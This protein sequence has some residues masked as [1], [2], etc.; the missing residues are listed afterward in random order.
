MSVLL[1]DLQVETE[2]GQLNEGSADELT[3]QELDD[4]GGGAFPFIQVA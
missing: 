1:S 3:D 2:Y 4:V